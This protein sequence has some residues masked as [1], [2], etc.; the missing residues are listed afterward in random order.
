MFPKVK[1]VFPLQDMRLC[2]R[3]VNGSTKHYDVSRLLGRLP[4]FKP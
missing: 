1:E 4:Q 3:L 2:V